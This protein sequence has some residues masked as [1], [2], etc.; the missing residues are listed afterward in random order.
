MSLQTSLQPRWNPNEVSGHFYY[1]NSYSTTIEIYR[2]LTGQCRIYLPNY[3]SVTVFHLRDVAIGCKTKIKSENVKI[4]QVPQYTDLK[5]ETMLTLAEQYPDV[6]KALPDLKREREKLP[7][8]YI[9]NVLYTLLGDTFK[10]WVEA[11]IEARN[12]YLANKNK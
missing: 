11:R 12:S 5:I 10:Q 8:D 6:M 2:F 7:R 9:A 4:F 1:F 3:E